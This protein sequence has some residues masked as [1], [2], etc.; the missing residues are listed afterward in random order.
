MLI[1]WHSRVGLLMVAGLLCG[2]DEID[3]I[4]ASPR[5]VVVRIGVEADADMTVR[6]LAGRFRQYLPSFFSRMTIE[7]QAD[8]LTFTFEHGAP[9]YKAIEYLVSHQGHFM[10]AG[11]DGT[12]WCTE[13][14]LEDVGF[15]SWGEGRGL[16]L[17]T[18]ETTAKR[19]AKLSAA[20]IGTRVTASLDGEVLMTADVR[21]PLQAG[22]LLVSI[23]NDAADLSLMA[24][25]LRSGALPAKASI[26]RSDFEK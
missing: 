18:N 22:R 20:S 5:H 21:A 3:Y 14:D 7:K 23:K 4:Q 24:T 19:I 13:R 12:V 26:L 8:S 11:A 1:S 2:C 17:K 6:V 25:M 16:H 10:L 9:P 15:L